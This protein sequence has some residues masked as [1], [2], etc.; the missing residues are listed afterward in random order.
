MART[1]PAYDPRPSASDTLLG[2]LELVF[3]PAITRRQTVSVLFVHGIN[4]GAW[5][6]GERFLDYF[7][8]AGFDA[9]AMSLRGH[10]RSWGGERIRD[11]GLADYVA[12]LVEVSGRIDGP[13]VLVGHSLGG[14]VVQKFIQ[15][16][17]RAAG[18]A[19]MA[20][21]PPWGLA[22]SAIRMAA[23]SPGMFAVLLEMSS[24]RRPPDD[25]ALLRRMLFSPETVD[26]ELDQFLFRVGPESPRLGSEL[27]GWPPLAPAP[28]L[29]PKAFVLGGA[30]DLIIPSDEVWRTGL[31]YG[32][33]PEL[34]PGL[35]HMV[36]S[37]PRWME[38]A[39]RLTRWLETSFG[40]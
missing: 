24:G 15:G 37:G 38:P 4:V 10:G 19:L 31:Y 25:K 23:R 17:G 14:A 1:S 39:V 9:Y 3:R 28:W 16:G 33:L 30:D 20:S 7:A 13:A 6:W 34:V 27:Q 29:A 36:M 18:M 11:W 32:C 35:G 5:V 26:D 12:D 2:D 22:P 40:P 8:E 21:V